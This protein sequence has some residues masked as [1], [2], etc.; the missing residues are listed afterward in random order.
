MA[1]D[2][3]ALEGLRRSMGG[4]YIGSPAS[5]EVTLVMHDRVGRVPDRIV[6]TVQARET[7]E[8]LARRMF[9]SLLLEAYPVF[10]R[11]AD[12]GLVLFGE[13]SGTC[14]HVYSGTSI[15]S[16]RTARGTEIGTAPMSLFRGRTLWV[17]VA[18]EAHVPSLLRGDLIVPILGSQYAKH[19]RS[20]S[21]SITDDQLYWMQELE[22]ATMPGTLMS[23]LDS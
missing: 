13:I 7:F 6:V 10:V 4:I 1:R 11:E 18:F 2:D 14:F 8:H 23:I 21:E 22:V 17:H 15:V 3:G 19:T 5:R 9:N 20:V 16:L 12:G